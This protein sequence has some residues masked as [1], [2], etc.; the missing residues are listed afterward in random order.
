MDVNKIIMESIQDVIGDKLEIPE[1]K[2]IEETVVVSETAKDE[3]VEEKKVEVVKEN[4]GEETQDNSIIDS[5]KSAAIAAGLGALCL[6]KKLSSL[7]ESKSQ[8]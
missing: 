7:N 2:I 4:I 3:V 5:A 8:K 1:T 6:R